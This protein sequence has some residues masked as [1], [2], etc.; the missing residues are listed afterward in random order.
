VCDF[1]RRILGAHARDDSR[2][3]HRHSA[4]RNSD[5]DLPFDLSGAAHLGHPG[6]DL[7]Q[8][9]PELPGK[10]LTGLGR[11]QQPV[12]GFLEQWL[13][14][15]RFKRGDDLANRRRAH[16]KLLRNAPDVVLLTHREKDEHILIAHVQLAKPQAMSFH[17]V[18]TLFMKEDPRLGE[19]PERIAH[20]LSHDERLRSRECALRRALEQL[21]AQLLFELAD[22]MAERLLRSA[23]RV[24]CS[25]QAARIDDVQHANQIAQIRISRVQ[26]A[27]MLVRAAM[28]QQC[29][30]PRPIA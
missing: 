12:P 3:Q 1:Q 17:G 11:P 6:A 19:V 23:Y 14:G 26:V 20:P 7:P 5:D 8:R 4:R 15:P 30:Q 27:S 16:T 21:H 22:R 28:V 29:M 13:C 10:K 2:Q 25:G 9:A 18:R 24:R